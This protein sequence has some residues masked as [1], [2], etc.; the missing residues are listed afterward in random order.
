VYFGKPPPLSTKNYVVFNPNQGRVE[1][2]RYI[3]NFDQLNYLVVS[4]VDMKSRDPKKTIPLPLLSSSTFYLK[5]DLKYFLTFEI[6]QK[7]VQS[8]LEAFKVGPIRSIVRVSFFYRFLKLNFELG[9]YT[10]VSLFSNSV[11][12]PAIMYNPL[13]GQKNLNPGSGFYYGFAVTDNP[14]NLDVRSNIPAYAESGLFDFFKKSEP[15]ADTYWLSITGPER[16]MYFEVVPSAEMKAKQNIPTLF[17]DAIS[18]P[19][20]IATRKSDR[21]LPLGKS[22]V[23]LALHFDLTKFGEGQHL[24]SFKLLFDNQN[25]PEQMRQFQTLNKWEILHQR[26]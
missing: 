20:V 2:S 15:L 21:A 16:M 18:G 8:T 9:M 10:E 11:I 23:N 13:E 12:L 14:A 22:P 17:K 6:H 1:T 7:D 3:Y 5:A 19:E 25:D 4:G 24:I 26:L